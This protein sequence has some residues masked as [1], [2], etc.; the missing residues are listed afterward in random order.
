MFDFD[1]SEKIFFA[2]DVVLGIYTIYKIFHLEILLSLIPTIVAIY[3]IYTTHVMH[4]RMKIIRTQLKIFQKLSVPKT[5][6]LQHIY[7]VHTRLCIYQSQVSKEFWSKC[8]CRYYL[9]SIPFNVLLVVSLVANRGFFVQIYLLAY[10]IF[11]AS[12]TLF[13][14]FLLAHQSRGLHKIKSTLVP[15][16]HAI[17]GRTN[18]SLKLRYDDLF[19]RLIRGRKYG[20]NI[21]L[22]GIIT[23][24]TI[25]EVIIIIY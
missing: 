3:Q 20:Q 19:K 21:E 5:T 22:I 12:L 7:K 25:Y 11:H 14:S 13:P 10:L 18:L 1:I 24:K 9:M 2:F 4:K 8:L 17:N 6:I 16:I 15:I 23:Y